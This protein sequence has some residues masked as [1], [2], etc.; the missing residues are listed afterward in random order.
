[1]FIKE[2]KEFCGEGYDAAEVAKKISS[3]F[4][5]HQPDIDLE[6]RD[7]MLDLMTMEDGTEFE[8]TYEKFIKYLS[9][10]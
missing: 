3:L 8:M 9:K 6:L 2:I 4:N 1:M 10:V 7:I 5:Q